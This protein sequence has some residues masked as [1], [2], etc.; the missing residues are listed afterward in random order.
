MLHAAHVRRVAGGWRG[1]VTSSVSV[2][3]AVRA[4]RGLFADPLGPRKWGTPSPFGYGRSVTTLSLGVLAAALVI[5]GMGGRVT[6]ALG[7][8]PPRA[9]HLL[10]SPANVQP[11]PIAQWGAM[12]PDTG[13]VFFETS[14]PLTAGDEDSGNDVYVNLGGVVDKVSADGTNGWHAAFEGST[15]DGTAAVYGTNEPL[16]ADDANS[17]FDLYRWQRADPSPVLITGGPDAEQFIAISTDGTRVAFTTLDPLVADDSDDARDVY[18]WDD[19]TVRLV[20][21]KT[22]SGP[23][24]TNPASYSG[25]S[26]DLT[27]IL[28]FEAASLVAGAPASG[29]FYQ[30]DDG[31]LALR[32]AD[33]AAG[34]AELSEDGKVLTFYS[35]LPLVAGDTNGDVDLFV[36][37]AG[38]LHRLTD[39]VTSNVLIQP[40][41][42]VASYDIWVMFSTEESLDP[43]DTDGQVDVYQWVRSTDDITLLTPSTSQD[44]FA[45]AG[46]ATDRFAIRTNEALTS[47][48]GDSSEDEYLVDQFAHTRKLLTSGGLG[49]AT[50]LHLSLLGDRVLYASNAN[51]LGAGPGLFEVFP[52]TGEVV[53]IPGSS[54]AG[55]GDT[56]ATGKNI[57]FVSTAK[58][59]AAD[60]N[61]GSDVYLSSADSTPPE[62][63]VFQIL[64]TQTSLDTVTVRFDALDGGVRFE[65]HLDDHAW[66]ACTSPW[67]KSGISTEGEHTAYVRAYDEVGNVDPTPGSQTWMIVLT[68]PTGTVSINSG[69]AVARRA[70]VRVKVTA[71]GNP[72]DVLISS[73][74]ATVDGGCPGGCDRLANAIDV[75]Y[76]YASASNEVLF[77]LTEAEYGG[78]DVD[79]LHTVYVQWEDSLGNLS[80]PKS[81]T[82]TLDRSAKVA[83]TITVKSLTN[84]VSTGGGSWLE[85]VVT[86]AD[87]VPVDGGE[88]GFGIQG[89]IAG[90]T[91]PASATVKH[92]VTGWTSGSHL[93][94]A[95]FSG[96]DTLAGSQGTTT[97]LV[98]TDTV[99]PVTTAPRASLRADRTGSG[100]QIPV[101]LGW[102]ASDPAPGFGIARYELRRSLDGGTWTSVSTSLMSNVTYQ[103]LASGHTYRFTVRAIDKVGNASPWETGPSLTLS[104]Y[105]ESNSRISYRST[106]TRISSS[107][108]NGG[109]VRYAK[110]R[111]ASASMS[112]TARHVAW[113]AALGPSRG[114]ARVYVDGSVV[115]TV[116]L[117]ASTTTTRRIVFAKSWTTSGSHS[118]R[119][120]VLGTDG[121]PRVDLDAV[122]TLR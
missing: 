93:V 79:G 113:M 92:W 21:G 73:S 69:A 22:P 112:F 115:A 87:G 82:I 114:K 50:L 62:T 98:G 57:A 76:P 12:A 100:S 13:A 5:L 35:E 75:P 80:L 122:A 70:T 33:P 67:T 99:K 42:T 84:P 119:I 105:S 38:A 51:V 7:A 19:G 3:R 34:I 104:R 18:L 31:T 14:A 4:R 83:T 64:P 65:C 52:S 118:I 9:P 8:E 32:L 120:V 59:V 110:T 23:T 17:T 10:S 108:Y 25:G 6:G 116:D 53:Q 86:A 2:R 72:M 96:S 20:S 94:T 46:R 90:A 77:D 39:G 26:W 15:R 44:A 30:W 117:H 95:T 101:R 103:Q 24:G 63:R 29:G 60:T 36:D 81:D 61:N 56:S 121:H 97:Q 58:L 16:V 78:T 107:A 47:G 109:A 89:M 102:T 40:H 43:S 111:G 68:A 41:D 48:D 85:A 28:F 54:A 27:T 106:W 49:G 91:Y 37:D 55:Y 88:V 1:S 66:E 11:V 71:G 45:I 74:P